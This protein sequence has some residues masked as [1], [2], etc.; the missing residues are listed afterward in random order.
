MSRYLKFL[1]FLSIATFLLLIELLSNFI[2]VSVNAQKEDLLTPI[3][4][5]T[6]TP[7]AET[8]SISQTQVYLPLIT[9]KLAA[10]PYLTPTP[11]PN[12]TPL[13]TIP[14]S[15]I[16]SAP[17]VLQRVPER[18]EELAPEAAIELTFDRPMDHKSVESLFQ[19][20]YQSSET[21]FNMF[22]EQIK[23]PSIADSLPLTGT[24]TW[25]N[26]HTMRFQPA[27]PLRRKANYEAKVAAEAHDLN[28][29]TLSDPIVFKFTT[30]GYLEIGQVSPANETKDVA[31]DATITL[32]FNRPVVSIQNSIYQTPLPQPLTFTP[33]ISGQGEWI[34]TSIYTF[35]PAKPLQKATT[36]TAKVD[37]ALKDVKGNSI[38]DEGSGYSWSFTT[39]KPLPV[40]VISSSPEN[41]QD[42]VALNPVIKVIFNQPIIFDT[43]DFAAKRFELRSKDGKIVSGALGIFQD[44]LIFTPSEQ[45][46]FNQDYEILLRAGL[47]SKSNDPALSADY[48]STFHTIPFPRILKTMPSEGATDVSPSGEIVITFNA[49]IDAETVANHVKIT[50]DLKVPLALAP[51]YI[52]DK[53]SCH[54]SLTEANFQLRPTTSYTLYIEPGIADLYGNV[55]TQALKIHFRTDSMPSRPAGAWFDAPGWRIALVNAYQPARISLHTINMTNVQLS[56]YSLQEDNPESYSSSSEFSATKLIRRWKIQ[57]TNLPN[58]EMVQEIAVITDGVK[59]PVGLYQIELDN[60][61]QSIHNQWDRWDYLVQKT[62]FRLLVSNVN[63]T[64]KVGK[65]EVL[66]WAN[67]FQSGKPVAGLNLAFFAPGQSQS[68]FNAKYSKLG[69]SATDSDGIAR[70]STNFL[71][72]SYSYIPNILV[73]GQ[74]STFAAVSS[75]WQIGQTSHY[76]SNI[77]ILKGYIYTERPIYRPNQTVA[78]KGILRKESDVQFSLFPAGSVVNVKINDSSWQEVYQQSFTLNANGTFAGELKLKEDAALGDYTITANIPTNEST[79][80]F[81]QTFKVA[82]YRAPEFQVN[83]NPETAEVLLGKPIRALVDVSYFAGGQVAEAKVEWNV[84]AKES[85][86]VSPDWAKRYYFSTKTPI[87]SC[88]DCEFIPIAGQTILTGTGKTDAQGHFLIDLPTDLKD[89][90]GKSITS[91][92]ELAIEASVLGKDFQ[93]ITN[94]GKVIAHQSEVYVGIASQKYFGEVNKAQQIDLLTLNPAGQRQPNIKLDVEIVKIEQDKSYFSEYNYWYKGYIQPKQRQTVIEKRS[95]KTDE[96][97]ETDFFFMPPDSGSYQIIAQGQDAVG[98]QNRSLLTLWVSGQGYASWQLGSGDQINLIANKTSYKP[99]ETA[100]ILIPSPF[101]NPHWA[102]I[103]IERGSIL[104]HSVQKMESNSLVYRLPITTNY[105]PNIYVSV[106]LFS[107]SAVITDVQSNY[108]ITLPADYKIGVLSLDVLP[109]AQTIQI[110][111]APNSPEVEPGQEL[112][113]AITVTNGLGEATTSELSLDLVDKAVLSL[114]PRKANAI[115]DAFYAKRDLAIATANSASLL[116]N[117]V[118]PSYAIANSVLPAPTAG[119][120]ISLLPVGEKGNKDSA[121]GNAESPTIRENFLDTAYWNPTI[122]TDEQGK[123]TI[124]VKLPDNLTT[125]VMRGVGVTADT[126][127]GEGTVEVFASKLLMI[128]PV[129]PRF[130]VVNDLVE[131][132]ANVSNRTDKVLN[133]QVGLTTH[134]LT[135]TDQLTQTIQILAKSEKQ[136]TWRGIVQDVDYADLVFT[137]ISGSYGDASKPRLATGPNGTL[138]VYRYLGPVT[139]LSSASGQLTKAMTRTEIVA[140]SSK[141]TSQ[142][143]SLEIRLDASL[144][145]GMQDGLKYLEHYPYE[146]TEQALSRFLPNILTA[147][148]LRQLGIPNTDLEQNL[149]NLVPVGL[150]KLYSRQNAAGGWGWWDNDVSNARISAYVVFGL[151]KTKEAGFAIDES[152]LLRGLNYLEQ[153]AKQNSFDTFAD[154]NQQAWVAFVLAESGHLD[155]ETLT[156]IYNQREKLSL[157]ARAYLAMAFQK[158]NSTDERIKTLLSDLQIAVSANSMGNYWEEKQ[159]DWWNM[160]TD[161]RSTAIILTALIRLD[162]EN[163]LNPNIVRW[164]MA[165]RK[166]KVWETTQETAWSLMA[167]TD[168]MSYTKELQADYPYAVWL[169]QKPQLSG[170]MDQSKLTQSTELHLSLSKLLRDVSNQLTINRGEGPGRL[171]Y[172]AYL[173][174]SPPIEEVK[175]L[176]HGVIVQRRY[177]LAS[178]SAGPKCPEINKAKIGDEIRVELA[179]TAPKPLPYLLIEDPLPAGTEAIDPSLATNS[180]TNQF[181]GD[182]STNYYWRYWWY[183]WRWYDRSE[184]RDDKIVLFSNYLWKGSFTYTYT[185]RATQPGEFRV[186]PPTAQAL[187]FPEIMGHGAGQIFTITR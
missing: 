41:K 21:S 89:K 118:S 85:S 27:Q 122:L 84:T 32:F 152:V 141:N 158:T 131:L 179:L 106:V 164:L 72:D 66:A 181:S 92:T 28:G 48:L 154:A 50:P 38:Y 15:A 120:P 109:L 117:R 112:T 148:A 57:I 73:L 13:P 149:T 144:A 165:I 7:G 69:T 160:N 34:N 110:K 135:I 37:I 156:K 23:A 76:P 25:P 55:I 132:A 175:P 39:I 105:A 95:L 97:G 49:P 4:N 81:Y 29:Q 83:V 33:P 104:S 153:T 163:A 64:L 103:T 143:G 123:V 43:T 70:I 167:L 2:L 129:T 136:V 60:A 100:E 183:W 182:S 161:T 18:G 171:Y 147:R 178:C 140:L 102:L 62:K 87:L 14:A 146:C 150:S 30:A 142:N 134:S 68:D 6:V 3:A 173:Q 17:I 79:Q 36:Y 176:D 126:K 71:F 19:L 174:T 121:S 138:P 116:L 93:K 107:P 46:A 119:L 99:G 168:W 82:A 75:L 172:T 139:N 96:H 52:D 128:R 133:V 74:Q 180:A 56:L 9:R 170:R 45:L 151:L 91:T 42:S 47:R 125:W 22:A 12:A 88:W 80:T 31:P 177:T 58:E 98:R 159:L 24:F 113:Y 90:S 185:I 54:F 155:S 127:V 114:L 65:N 35:V 78:F 59:L 137:A 5:L 145:A 8:K 67:D 166:A 26:T 77:P 20:T 1:A 101:Q 61:P 51:K 157:Y 53:F 40:A 16:A 63:I 169:N 187:Y 184:L 108:A 124:K 86:F 130:L 162:P 44:T 111:L 94:S 186:I 115:K 10:G 11:D